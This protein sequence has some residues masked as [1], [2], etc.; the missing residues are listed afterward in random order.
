MKQYQILHSGDDNQ[1]MHKIIL[2]H[3]ADD[4]LRRKSRGNTTAYTQYEVHLPLLGKRSHVTDIHNE[5]VT[6]PE[7]DIVCTLNKCNFFLHLVSFVEVT[8]LSGVLSLHICSP[9]RTSFA[10]K[11]I[12][13]VQVLDNLKLKRSNQLCIFFRYHR[14]GWVPNLEQDHC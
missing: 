4:Y 2:D 14:R 9:G 11:I 10:V 3:C 1:A 13:T 12:T 7:I 8:I 6:R 5:V